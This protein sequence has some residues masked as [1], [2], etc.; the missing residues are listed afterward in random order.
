MVWRPWVTGMRWK[1]APKRSNPAPGVVVDAVELNAGAGGVAV[2]GAEGVVEDA[3]DGVCGLVVGVD[4][5]AVR[6]LEAEGAKVVEAE[7]VVGVAVGVEDGV[8]VA[9]VLAD[10]LGVEVRAGV[11]EDDVVVVGEAERGAGAAI[12]RVSIWRNGRGADG[13]VAAQRRDTHGGAGAEEG[14]GCFHR[15]ADDA[16]ACWAGSGR[17]GAL[18]AAERA[19]AWVISR[20]AMRSSKR[21]LS[22]RRCSDS[23]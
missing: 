13:A 19:R 18:A 3:L 14:E 10:G 9:D 23:R 15:S 7:D 6:D 1:Q 12:A 5:K 4:G 20:N 16:R 21:A 2:V 22:S 8:D 11:D 17:S